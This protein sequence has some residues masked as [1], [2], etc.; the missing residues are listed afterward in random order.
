[1]SDRLYQLPDTFGA[2][3][4]AIGGGV[5]ATE[6][7]STLISVYFFP[8]NAIPADITSGNPDPSG[9][10]PGGVPQGMFSGDCATLTHVIDQQIRI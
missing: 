3:F 7:T 4:N 6:W 8:R 1:L 10:G 2:G 9:W 5:C